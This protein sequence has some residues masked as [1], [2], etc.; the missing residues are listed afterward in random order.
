[1]HWIEHGFIAVYNSHQTYYQINIQP[2]KYT[3]GP[4]TLF[5]FHI[6][7]GTQKWRDVMYSNQ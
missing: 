4:K 1:M 5:L 7:T 3:H 6:W 2:K